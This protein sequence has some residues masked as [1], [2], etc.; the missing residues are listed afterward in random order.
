MAYAIKVEPGTKVDLSAIDADADGGLTKREGEERLDALAEELGDLQE[1]LFAAGSRALLSVFQGMDTSGKDGA[2][3]GVFK[4]MNPQGVRV[5]SF[6][7]PTPLERAHDFLWRCHIQAP[8]LGM[9]GIFNRSHYEAVLVERVK[10]IVPERVWSKRYGQIVAFEG[11]L[12]AANTTVLKFYL[13][14]SKDEQKQRLLDREADLA[15]AWKLNAGDWVERRQWDAYQAAFEEALSRTSTDQAPW[16]IIP[17][18]R[19]WYRNL[20][21]AEAICEALRPYQDDWK[22]A[23]RQRGAEELPKVLAER[24][25]EEVGG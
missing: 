23:L 20:A 14:I 13:H 7:V 19:K 4:D 21:I 5:A 17:A 25:R 8:E 12:T 22:E 15:K 10:H 24:A 2:I 11:T 6:G 18:N 16:F 3:R 9:V 1:L